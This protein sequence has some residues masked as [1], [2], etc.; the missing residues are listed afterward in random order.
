MTKAPT[1]TE[2]SK[3]QSDN[4]SNVTKTVRLHNNV[5]KQFDDTVIADR[6]PFT[7][8]VYEGTCFASMMFIIKFSRGRI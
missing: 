4:T 1:P 5:T 7:I 6:L 2:M 8:L 3:G